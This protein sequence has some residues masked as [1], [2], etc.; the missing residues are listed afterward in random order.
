MLIY[1]PTNFSKIG[2]Y[3]ILLQHKNDRDIWYYETCYARYAPFSSDP[4][5][6]RLSTYKNYDNLEII[7]W[8][9]LGNEFPEITCINSMS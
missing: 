6:Y 1:K 7:G 3:L 9:Y 8:N 5:L 2:Y 4:A